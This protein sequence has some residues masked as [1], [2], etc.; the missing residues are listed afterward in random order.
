MEPVVGLL[1]PCICCIW[2]MAGNEGVIMFC[3]FSLK[4]GGAYLK[5]AGTPAHPDILWCIN[6]KI[7]E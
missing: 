1:V 2:S 6:E 7:S 3:V 5:Q 4:E